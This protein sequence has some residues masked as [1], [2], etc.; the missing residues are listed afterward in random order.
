MVKYFLGFI[1][2]CFFNNILNA[3]GTLTGNYRLNVDLY[4]L[5]SSIKAVGPNYNY[6]KNS[7]NAWFQVIYRDNN[8]GFEAGVRF[9][10]NYNS[11]LQT[12]PIPIT[13]YGIGNWYIKKQIE[14]LEVMGGYIYEQYGSGIALR[15]FEERNLGIDNAIFGV[16]AK[17]KFSDNYSLRTIVGTQKYRFDHFGSFVKGINFE[18]NH[19]FSEKINLSFGAAVVSRTLTTKDR[20]IV[21]NTVAT[22]SPAEY[23]ATPYNT[24]VG[25]WYH[26]LQVGGV[27]WSV[28]GAYKTKEAVFNQFN[29]K[30][31][32]KPGISVF[33]TLSYSQKGFGITWQARYLDHYQFQSTAE[34]AVGDFNLNNNR[35]LAFLAPINKQNSLRLPARFQISPVD[36]GEVGTSIDLTYS[37]AKKTHINLNLCLL[38]SSFSFNTPYYR[39]AYLDIEQK[40]LLNGKMDIHFGGQ[41]VF[42]NQKKYIFEGVNDVEAYTFF[43]EPTIRFTRKNSLRIELQYQSAKKDIGE[44]VFALAEYN[45]APNWSF[46]VSDLWNFAP[47]K[48]YEVV[49]EY[50]NSHHFWSAFASY[51]KDATR[52]TIAY[53]KQL[54]GVVCT[55][56]VCRF[57]PAFSGLRMQMTSSF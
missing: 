48:N 53:V 10:G 31:V 12:P 13:N 6:N 27:S 54:A 33:N 49:K 19:N 52:F 38:D 43:V 34:G 37:P 3:Q 16:K 22:Y 26:T 40:K 15:T 4:D 17:Y 30:Y 29:S 46:A 8:K 28:D 41:Y 2:I 32:Y 24:Y 50:R 36:I 44:S 20:E 21:D 5:D 18:G 51:T 47:N 56:G 45:I 35:R 57:E 11:I 25:N 55:G 14:K 23:F 39:E 9:D 7:A 42:Y 1:M